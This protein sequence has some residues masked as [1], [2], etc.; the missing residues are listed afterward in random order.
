MGQ[1]L[2]EGEGCDKAEESEDVYTDFKYKLN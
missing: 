1:V 2:S